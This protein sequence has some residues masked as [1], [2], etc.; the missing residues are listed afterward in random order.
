MKLHTGAQPRAQPLQ[1][2]PVASTQASP[3]LQSS[4]LLQS[5]TGQPTLPRVQ[6]VVPSNLVAQ[7]QTVS[8]STSVPQ[9]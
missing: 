4:S 6:T 1:N 5:S 2:F 7:W 3:M 8:K 9:T